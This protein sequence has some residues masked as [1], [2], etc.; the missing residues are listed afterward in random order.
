MRHTD[1][2]IQG[3]LSYEIQSS[4]WKARVFPCLNGK[5]ERNF[6]WWG[7]LRLRQSIGLWGLGGGVEGLAGE[8]VLR[9]GAGRHFAEI[10]AL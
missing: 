10:S 1:L 6:T 8:I 3:L 2:V 5:K 9:E 7:C 4:I